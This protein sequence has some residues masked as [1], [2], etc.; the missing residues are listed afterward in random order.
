[1]KKYILKAGAATVDIT[2][3][4]SMFLFGYPHVERYS[5][6]THDPLYASALVL[7]NG[8]TQI[9]FCAIDIIFIGKDQAKEVRELVNQKT[10][11]PEENIMISAS[12]R[13]KIIFCG[14]SRIY[15]RIYAQ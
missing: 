5:K 13:F 3:G 6:G 12:R 15:K 8:H 1:M 11:I 2:P 9:V 14:F 7:D 4:K 10:G